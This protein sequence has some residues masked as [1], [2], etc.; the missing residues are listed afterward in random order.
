MRRA[1]LKAG[2]SIGSLFL[3]LLTS[4][5]TATFAEPSSRYAVYRSEDNGRSW[6]RSSDGIPSASR[7]NAFTSAEN[8]VAAG[9]DVGVFVS[10][11]SGKSWHAPTLP[12]ANNFRVTALATLNSNFLFAGTTE[13]VLLSSRD[14][15]KTWQA[16][17]S[18]PRRNIRSLHTVAES[19][20]V[21][22]DSD[23]V[24]KSSDL[25]STWTHLSAGLPPHSQV[26]A[27]ASLDGQVF[28]GL[29][30]QG[31]YLWTGQ[32]WRHIAE[33]SNIKPLALASNGKTLIAGHNP[34]GIHWSDDH[35][36]TWTRW[37]LPPAQELEE[38]VT[39]FSPLDL[40]LNDQTKTPVATLPPLEAPIW[41]MSAGSNLAI[42]GAA[43]RIYYS[44]DH[45]RTW[46]RAAIGLPPAS[47][48]IAF[49]VQE[50]LLLA[51]I[52]V[53]HPGCS[54]PSQSHP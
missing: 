12:A 40:L 54:T 24:Y 3:A 43:D 48:G 35:G 34:G 1:F 39:Q 25:G 44:T 4:V 8:L 15:G 23:H 41:E 49:L 13:G 19:L 36:G 45:A 10:T 50:N 51:A 53:R 46:T 11:N 22:T 16:N 47:S 18:F 2:G 37:T 21:G 31:L 6:I 32:K 29:Y 17:K 14:H 5:F 27:L 28:A 26:F 30:A 20:Y 33:S 42:A 38:D 9:T 52:H 7:I